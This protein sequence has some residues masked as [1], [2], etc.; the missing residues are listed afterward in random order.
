MKIVALDCA[1]K[2]GWAVYVN[3]KYSQSGVQN[4]TKKRGESSGLMFLKFS[5]WLRELLMMTKPDLVAYEQ[6]FKRGGAATEIS[7]GLTTNVQE[8]C[9][10]LDINYW[11]ATVSQVKKALTGRGGANKDQMIE[12]A[13]PIIGRNPE[14]DDEADA[15]GVAL[16]AIAEFSF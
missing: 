6:S 10:D 1:S 9:V 13:K 2:T 11:P 12:A 14:T 15:V 5:C 16:A 7:Y 4:F 3:G 8:V